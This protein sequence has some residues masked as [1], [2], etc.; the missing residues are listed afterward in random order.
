MSVLMEDYRT[1][2]VPEMIER[3][4]YSN[5]FAVPRVVKVVV[6]MR[7]ASSEESEEALEQAAKVMAVVTGQR[8]APRRARKSVSGFKI[9]EGD[10]VGC[11]ATLRG[12]R[13]YEFLERLINV[14]IPRVRDFRGLS[15]EAF[16]G[17][18][19]Y[20]LGIEEC[21][22]FP[23][24]N[25]DEVKEARGVNITVVTTSRTDEEAEHLLR[26]LGMPLRDHEEAG[27]VS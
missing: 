15:A 10:I 26:L 19:N 21:L 23:E 4:K 13:M 1:R 14:A 17:R 20:S 2:I 27:S 5:R 16:D 18:G 22:I 3:F 12:R 25:P 11:V 7:I 6:S 8:P 24:L 9:R